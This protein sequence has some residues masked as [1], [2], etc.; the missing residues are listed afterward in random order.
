MR[1]ICKFTSSST[2]N[3]QN[4]QTIGVKTPPPGRPQTSVKLLLFVFLDTVKCA[5]APAKLEKPDPSEFPN[6]C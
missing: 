4:E 2:Q 1:K 6:L 3:E 5:Q